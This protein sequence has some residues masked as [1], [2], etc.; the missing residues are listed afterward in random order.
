MHKT[1]FIV[2]GRRSIVRRFTR[3][4]DRCSRRIEGEYKVFVTSRPGHA[5]S[6]GKEL[7]LEGHTHL[8][9]VGGDGTLH[10]VVNGVMHSQHPE[11]T[12]GLVPAGTANDYAKSIHATNDLFRLIENVNQAKYQR[13]NVGAIRLSDGLVEY[14]VN[15][16]DMGLGVDVVKRVN[17]SVKI[18]G[19]NLTFSKS[20][21]QSFLTYKNQEVS[22]QAA[23]WSWEGKINSLVIANGKYF[24]SG[25]CIAPDAD[26]F[27]DDFSIVI[28]GDVSI[29]DYLKYIGKIKKG[30]RIDHPAV[31]YRKASSLRIQSKFGIEA[32]GEYIGELPHAVEI[33]KR[34]LKMLL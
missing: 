6:L 2:H 26:V 1:A 15:I 7:A 8:V 32:D 17:K 10:E 23:D 21:L 9:A 4:F 16:A 28:I 29:S 27:G 3:E 20:I 14:F 5:K 25:M 11:C 22:L 34:S 31:H 24:G 12:V 13:V 19:P 18:L 33:R 30:E